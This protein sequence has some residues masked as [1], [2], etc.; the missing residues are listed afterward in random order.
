MKNFMKV[1][2]CV[3]SCESFCITLLTVSAYFQ[4][5]FVCLLVLS[6]VFSGWIY[7][8]SHHKKK[9]LRIDI[10]F[11]SLLL[12]TYF[13]EFF[14]PLILKYQTVSDFRLSQQFD[15]VDKNKYFF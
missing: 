11:F 4:S 9:K 3:R 14:S 13:V 2:L 15:V 1:I 6:I 7:E 5:S 8:I 10:F 12:E